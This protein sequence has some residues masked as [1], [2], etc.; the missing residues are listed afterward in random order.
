MRTYSQAMASYRAH[1]S[2][3][4]GK[5]Y[6][7]KP[8]LAEQ[9]F[10]QHIHPAWCG[11]LDAYEDED[12]RKLYGITPT[13]VM[14]LHVFGRGVVNVGPV[15]TQAPR[16]TVYPPSHEQNAKG[17]PVCYRAIPK[18]DLAKLVGRSVSAVE[19][20]LDRL[21]GKGARGDTL[22]SHGLCAV[23]SL[24]AGVVIDGVFGK[25]TAFAFM[26]MVDEYEH[27]ARVAREAR[28]AAGA[29]YTHQLAWCERAKRALGPTSSIERAPAQLILL[30]RESDADAHP[31]PTEL[32]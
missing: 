3:I 7:A 23:L 31:A 10:L 29:T 26:Y 6:Y 2:E 17:E 15:R 27:D 19:E 5:G 13:T 32:Q 1:V 25:Q 11:A 22:Q 16:F 21:R 9:Y 4:I 20:G 12:V 14:L 28:T 30:Q 24:H 18:A 8:W